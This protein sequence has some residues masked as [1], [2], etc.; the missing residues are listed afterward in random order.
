MADETDDY[1]FRLEF[2]EEDGDEPVLR[3]IREELAPSERRALGLALRRYLQK[4]GKA[5]SY[6]KR[7]CEPVGEGVYEFKLRYNLKDLTSRLGLPYK[8]T[9]PEDT[10]DVMLRVF[11]HEHGGDVVLLLHGYDKGENPGKRH[12]QAQIK[13][14]IDRKKKWLARKAKEA[15][16]AARGGQSETGK[17]S[18]KKQKLG[19]KRK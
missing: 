16:D 12:Q 17:A 8:K 9:G 18:P 19:K 3:W 14:A 11:F 5:L 2:Y 6:N 4:H 10:Q 13:L 1:P 7:M 15:K